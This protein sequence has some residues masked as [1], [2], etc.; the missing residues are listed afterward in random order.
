MKKIISALFAAAALWGCTKGDEP[1]P[2]PDTGNHVTYT[3]S[4][5]TVEM[6]EQMEDYVDGVS[7]GTLTF[8]SGT[9]ESYIPQVGQVILNSRPS[10]K[11]PYGFLGKVTAVRQEGGSS[12][13]ETEK[14][15]L[16]QAFEKLNI[17][18][19]LDMGEYVTQVL[20][21]DRKPMNFSRAASTRADNPG[22]TLTI[23]IKKY[24]FGGVFSLEGSVKLSLELDLD[25]KV[26]N[27]TLTYFEAAIIKKIALTAEA[28]AAVSSEFKNDDITI[29]YILCA[30]IPIGPVVIVPELRLA[31]YVGANG[32]ISLSTTW[33]YE[34]GISHGVKYENKKWSTYNNFLNSEP[35]ENPIETDAEF[36]LKGQEWVGLS[37]GVFFGVYTAVGVG[38]RVIPRCIV[39][40]EFKI[41]KTNLLNGRSYA[42]LKESQLKAHFALSAEA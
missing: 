29:G 35:G 16:D 42:D 18:Q 5:E 32:E 40:S 27:K 8:R 14:V 39:S 21:P 30:P 4:P 9:P 37:A 6:D 24:E 34:T 10:E 13:V 7:E 1:N 3:F 2:G 26:E 41:D 11:M 19:S 15:A 12:V 33:T 25:M 38:I 31:L 36:T 22:I 23:P 17:R 20:D 28:K